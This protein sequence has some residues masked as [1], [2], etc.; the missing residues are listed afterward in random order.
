MLAYIATIA[1][2]LARDRYDAA[3]WQNSIGRIPSSKR[4][5]RTSK[6]CVGLVIENEGALKPDVTTDM[7]AVHENPAVG[8]NS[9]TRAK[10]IRRSR[11]RRERVVHR[12]PH[13]RGRSELL[14]IGY[15]DFPVGH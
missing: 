1:C 12:V 15:Q 4:H 9:M 8:H 5:S 14:P 7:S 6:P 10:D 2:A 13:L 11:D 3:I